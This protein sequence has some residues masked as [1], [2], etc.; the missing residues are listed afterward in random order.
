MSLHSRSPA[1]EGTGG[2]LQQ[3]AAGRIMALLK[4]AQG[5]SL[6]LEVCAGV[7]APSQIGSQREGL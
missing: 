4:I 1:D 6:G 7:A 2:E 3:G 5:P